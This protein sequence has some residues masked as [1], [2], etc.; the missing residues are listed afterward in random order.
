[1]PGEY[2]VVATFPGN[3]NYQ[4][5][6]ATAT[7]TITKSTVDIQIN[8]QDVTYDGQPH[9]AGVTVSGLPP[10][11]FA[12]DSVTYNGSDRE[13]CECRQLHGGRDV[14]R[15]RRS[16]RRRRPRRTFIIRKATSTVIVNG[17]T[18]TYNGQ[19]HPA[20]G[21]VT[22]IGEAPIG[23]PAFTYAGGAEPPVTV[24]TYDVVGTYAGS[25]NYEPASATT[26]IVILR[27]PA[28]LD[29]AV[30]QAIVYGT[31]LGDGAAQRDGE[32]AWHVRLFA[33]RRHGAERGRLRRC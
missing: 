24:G 8:V 30:P 3:A 12:P 13:S 2:T 11:F 18:F 17:G 10:D 19:P 16:T 20:T 32:R 21:F 27:A 7:L 33:G 5:G 22:G 14:Q 15:A 31:P 25:A 23:T 29:W 26:A 1:M 6:S 4:A 28:V 9:P